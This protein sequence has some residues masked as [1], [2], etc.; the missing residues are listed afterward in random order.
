[1]Y[2]HRYP[3]LDIK[4]MIIRHQLKKKKTNKTMVNDTLHI[5]YNFDLI[6]WF[7]VF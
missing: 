6:D 4:G 1:M 2:S 5:K 3:L 7:L